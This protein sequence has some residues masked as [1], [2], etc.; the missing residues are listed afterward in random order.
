[1]ELKDL[2]RQRKL[3]A[4]SA[5]LDL[6]QLFQENDRAL[7]HS[8]IQRQ[9]PQAD[10]VT[11]Y[12]NINAMLDHG[13]IHK[14][15]VN[16]NEVYYAMCDSL[17]TDHHHHHDHIHFHCTSCERVTCVEPQNPFSISIPGHSIT[18][19]EVAVTGVCQGCMVS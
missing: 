15:Q 17:C 10:R 16:S 12:R 4:T 1:M 8:E 7:S 9:F 13:L 19:V 3:K 6:L 14:A 2:L 11:M 5:R 18:E